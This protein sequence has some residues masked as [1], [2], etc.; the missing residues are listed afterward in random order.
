MLI[1]ASNGGKDNIYDKL[2]KIKRKYIHSSSFIE[3]YFYRCEPNLNSEFRIVDD[4]VYVKSSENY[5]YLWEKLYLALKAFENRLDEFD[6]ICRPNLSSFIIIDR[7]LNY[8]KNLPKTRY[9]GGLKF[10][11][12]QPIPF[13][14][15]YCFTITPDIAKYIL[16]NKYIIS[17]N[18]GI[19]DRCMGQILQ[20]MNVDIVPFDYLPIEYPWVYENNIIE[21]TLEKE[22]CFL[23]RIRH[24]LNENTLFGT[25][26]DDR[27]DKDLSMHCELLQ[28]F[29][30]IDDSIYA[31]IGAKRRLN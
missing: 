8:V 10:Y 14:S 3:S 19:D 31:E 23:I 24:L 27:V 20:I 2:Q 30:N 15:G 17:N 25:D 12:G 13:P 5:P 16:L 7:Y 11:G 22:T 6:F 26:V 18:Q 1:L 21:T 28:K 4:I 9:C 29:Y